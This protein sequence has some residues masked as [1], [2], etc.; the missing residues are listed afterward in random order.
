MLTSFIEKLASIG[1]KKDECN[2]AVFAKKTLTLLPFYIAIPALCWSGIYSFYGEM[3]VASV[4][5]LYLLLSAISL[6]IL[7]KTKGFFLFEITQ[8]ILILIL[9]F[10]FSWIY[11]D[12]HG[13]SY[14]F[15]WGFYA[16]ITAIMYNKNFKLAL[17]L[18]LIFCVLMFLTLTSDILFLGYSNSEAVSP[19]LIEIFSFL[20]FFM[21]CSGIFLLINMYKRNITKISQELRKEKQRLYRLT[22]DLKFANKELEKLATCDIVTNLPNRYYFEEIVEQMIA[23]AKESEKIFTVMFLDLDGFK[24]IN[25]TL[26]HD[27]GDFVL[28]TVGERLQSKLRSND[29]VARI[30]GDE[31]AVAINDIKDKEITKK[32]ASSL[33]E[34][35]NKPCRYKEKTCQVGVSI[36]IAMIDESVKTGHDILKKA[37][38]AMYAIKKSGKN[39]F[40][41]YEQ[42]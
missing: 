39:N 35:V 30:G 7:Y 1:L 4:P 41:F 42:G 19:E 32:I 2:D 22:N 14:S 33:I 8:L 37:D 3:V 10:A 21:A 11:N 6:L 24:D 36:G 20:N 31:F 18:F 38:L 23:E 26:G 27:A 40:G 13:G 29:I 5:L 15:I 12:I 9:P 17:S 25:D 16:P 34:V 28:K